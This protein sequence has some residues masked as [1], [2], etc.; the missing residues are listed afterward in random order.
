MCIC[1]NVP[2]S[3]VISWASYTFTTYPFTSLLKQIPDMILLHGNI[4]GYVSKRQGLSFINI[5]TIPL[6]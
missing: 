6:I 1:T 2:G 5:T 4:T 3:T